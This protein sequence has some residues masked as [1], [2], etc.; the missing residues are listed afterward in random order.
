MG[1]TENVSGTAFA[2]SHRSIDI[3]LL[4]N[5]LCKARDSLPE[6]LYILTYSSL[7]S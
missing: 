4:L 7:I 2:L 6:C 5:F 1:G 3:Q